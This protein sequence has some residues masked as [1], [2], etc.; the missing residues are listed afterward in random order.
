MAEDLRKGNDDAEGLLRPV[1]A[2][3]LREVLGIP[4]AEVATMLGTSATAPSWSPGSASRP[5]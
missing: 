2:L 3:L 4:A 1:V 5:P